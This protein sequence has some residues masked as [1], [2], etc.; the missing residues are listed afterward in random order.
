MKTPQL[1]TAILVALVLSVTVKANG[2]E[3]PKSV[4][5]H[6]VNVTVQNENTVALRA[7]TV[8][9]KRANYVVRVYAEDGEMVYATSYI[10]RN[11]IVKS[12]DL[13]EFPEGKYE[14]VVYNKLKPIYSREVVK[15]NIPDVKLDTKEFLVEVVK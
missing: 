3:K 2:T 15:H 14:F 9:N 10:T 12:Y 1:I 5:E 11:G 7:A 8:D 13:S 6:Q 4:I